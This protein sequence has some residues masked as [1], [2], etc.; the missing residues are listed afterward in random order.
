MKAI[1]WI[2]VIM[3]VG[4]VIMFL[5]GL[6]SGG[7]THPWSSAYTL[8][9]I[10]F[11]IVALVLFFINEWKL[12]RYPMMPLR[13]FKQRTTV[14]AY[15]VCFCHGFV[16]VGGTY[17]LPLYF[18]TVLSATP[19][20]SGVYIFPLAVTLSLGSAATGVF[21]KKVGRYR[22][23]I[24]FGMV[25]ITLGFGLLI[26]IPDDGQWAKIVIYQIIAGIGVGPNF[27]SPLIAIQS[28]LPGHDIATATATFG[29]VR[30]ISTSMSV[31]LGGV[32]FQNVLAKKES[33]I[34]Q[35][36]GPEVASRISGANLFAS[37]GFVKKLPP[38]QKVVVDRAIT[39]SMSKLFIFYTCVAAFGL[40]VSLFVQKKTLSKVHE[41]TKTGLEEQERV[42]REVKEQRAAKKAAGMPTPPGTGNKSMEV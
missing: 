31:V 14:A 1:D 27:Q 18:Q 3:V 4:G 21:I 35:A 5:L 39:S 9:L 15:V 12:A 10:I 26:D 28:H 11:G 34:A 17:Y 37:T 33:V 42:R 36:L 40:F 30:Q 25:F 38:A 16:F 2:G 32:V 8:C 41:K 22:E 13:L 23:P 19:I 24:W 29:F 20:L 7:L 6:E